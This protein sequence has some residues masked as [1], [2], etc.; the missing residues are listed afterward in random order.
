MALFNCLQLWSPN[1]SGFQE[2]RPTRIYRI[3]LMTQIVHAK[4]KIVVLTFSTIIRLSEDWCFNA[5][6]K[7]SKCWLTVMATKQLI[8]FWMQSNG[9]GTIRLCKKI[10]SSSS[11]MLKLYV[12]TN[13]TEWRPSMYIPPF[14]SPISITGAI[15]TIK[16]FLD[17]K[18]PI[19][20]IRLSLQSREISFILFI[21]THQL[22]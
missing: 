21:M 18:E 1:P 2:K 13:W 5:T 10:Q 7:K 17:P 19:E 8:T 15:S 16:S 4:L 6:K 20:W 14:L 11:S 3:M 9:L 22:W 12:K